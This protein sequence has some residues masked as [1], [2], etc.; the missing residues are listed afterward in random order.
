MLFPKKDIAL[1]QTAE[2]IAT[3]PVNN[4]TL[5]NKTDHTPRTGR[6]GSG[7]TKTVAEK[8]RLQGDSDGLCGFYSIINGIRLAL[9]PVGGLSND[10]ESELWRFLIRR[11][12]RKYRFATLFLQG[13]ATKQIFRLSRRAA[14]MVS[15]QTGF[16]VVFQILSRQEAED[17]GNKLDAIVR[18]LLKQER[19][20]I[21][22]G[23]ECEAY[24]HWSIIRGITSK[25]VW[26]LDS[27][28]SHRLLLKSCTLNSRSRAKGKP[29]Y[30]VGVYG[31]FSIA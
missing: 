17:C 14:K 29:R 1:S 31:T 16:N 20:A 21:L 10:N 28:G 19:T 7:R 3:H 5:F 25:S 9:E 2:T 11:A 30:R 15:K 26:L 27:D 23:I 13:T 12:D 6:G 4:G 22:A 24:D 8:P 18:Y